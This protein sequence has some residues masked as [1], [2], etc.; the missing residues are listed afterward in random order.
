MMKSIY[1]NEF[2][3]GGIMIGYEIKVIQTLIAL[4]K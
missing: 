4:R 3:G 2:L 1:E